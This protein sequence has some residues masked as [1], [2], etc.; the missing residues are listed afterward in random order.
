[1][2]KIAFPILLFAL[3]FS[4][5]A[6]Q[7]SLHG[8]IANPAA[9]RSRQLSIEF[10]NTDRW[11]VLIG[12]GINADNTFEITLSDPKPGQYRFRMFGENKVWADF[13]LPDSIM[14]ETGL[15]FALD[16]T[17]MDGRPAPTIGSK[18]NTLYASLITAHQQ[19]MQADA[20]EATVLELNRLCK[21]II[22][23][24][25]KALL[26]DIALLFYEP[27]K[28]D[29]AGNMAVKKMTANEFARAFALDKIPFEHA[30]ILRHNAF[31]KVLTQYYNYFDHTEAGGNA[32][33]DGIMARRNGNEAVDGYVFRYLLD[34]LMDEKNDASLSYLLKWYTPDCP[35]EEP[36]PDRFQK[37]VY[38]LK[39]C[40]PG[41]LAPDLNF[42]NL[43][44]QVVNLG[45]VCGQNKLT[46]LLFWRSTCS[47]C[48]EF[49]PVLMEIY[50]KYHPLGVEVY[51]LSSDRNEETLRYALQNQPTPWINVFIPKEQRDY[52]AQQ[53]PTPS[54][55]T[56][57]VLDKNRRVVT[58]VLSRDNLEAYFDEQLAKR[59]Q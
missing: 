22:G 4:Q 37:M 58:R 1:M 43:D 16:Y 50:K 5:L 48:K 20:P 17:Q 44:G 35:E 49:E 12:A 36:L 11:Q 38:A 29:Y 59:K 3:S 55:P 53:F 10:W 25:R 46:V 33:I 27:Q 18:T 41:N 2:N 6:A 45:T 30:N 13:I 34:K 14:G 9:G 56:L 52:I 7:F 54:T 47:H 39:V 15:A 57:I 8:T 19:R 24:Y 26:G 31:A 23:Q 40:T 21:D 42:A 28:E 32:Y 51:A